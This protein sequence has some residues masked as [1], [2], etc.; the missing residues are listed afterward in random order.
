MVPHCGQLGFNKGQ[1]NLKGEIKMK[2]LHKKP[3]AWTLVSEVLVPMQPK[4][5]SAEFWE[6]VKG[7]PEVKARLADGSLEVLEDEAVEEAKE[8]VA[9]KKSKKSKGE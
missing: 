2:L 6:A 7:H 5:V 1:L 4:E 3:H 9:E 8:P